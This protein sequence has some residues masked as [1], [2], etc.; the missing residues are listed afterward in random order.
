MK[1][2]R[3]I[4]VKDNDD[5]TKALKVLNDAL[6][7]VELTS[8]RLQVARSEVGTAEE[9]HTKALKHY[10]ATRTHLLKLVPEVFEPESRPGMEGWA[11]EHVAFEEAPDDE[12]L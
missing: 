4:T 7:E 9:A 6:A 12:P 11:D 3:T 1:N 8:K 5:R 10:D 2:G